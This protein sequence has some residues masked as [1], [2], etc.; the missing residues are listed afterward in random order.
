MGKI[1]TFV[2]WRDFNNEY[3]WTLWSNSDKIANCGEGYKNKQDMEAMI[4][5]IQTE[6]DIARI[7][8]NTNK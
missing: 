4:Y 8:D 6:A 7:Q 5:R 2:K 3:R 1:L